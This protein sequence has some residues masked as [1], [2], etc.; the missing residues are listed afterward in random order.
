MI[1]ENLGEITVKFD[2]VFSDEPLI[3]IKNYIKSF[4]KNTDIIELED[5]D[6]T[7]VGYFYLEKV[8]KNLFT[9]EMTKDKPIGIRG[10]K[11]INYG[12]KVKAYLS[13]WHYQYKQF[14][15]TI[16]VVDK[17]G[18]RTKI[19]FSLF[20]LEKLAYRYGYLGLLAGDKPCTIQNYD[21]S[22]PVFKTVKPAHLDTENWLLDMVTKPNNI[23]TKRNLWHAITHLI[24][25]SDFDMFHLYAGDYAS[26]GMCAEA[27]L[28]VLVINSST[29]ECKSKLSENYAK[30]NVV[31]FIIDIAVRQ[32]GPA[33]LYFFVYHLRETNKNKDLNA[34]EK[35]KEELLAVLGITLKDIL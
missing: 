23:S 24:I 1:V 22:I 15:Y 11:I 18:T 34:M 27:L 6:E 20:G 26:R 10:N 3:P 14:H 17:R 12:N 8:I 16:A 30:R 29:N 31:R 13:Y 25:I 33:F 28:S 35:F 2:K 4:D 19:L 7:S 5:I 21:C 9:I 32:Y